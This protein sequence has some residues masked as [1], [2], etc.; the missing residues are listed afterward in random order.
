MDPQAALTREEFYRGKE[1]IREEWFVHDRDLGTWTRLRV[2]SDGMADVWDHG[3]LWGFVNEACARFCIREGRYVHPT[4]AAG[5]PLISEASRQ[6]AEA[7][8]QPFRWGGD[9]STGLTEPDAAPD[10]AGYLLFPI[11]SSPRPPGR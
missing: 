6:Q 1:V 5:G 10:P 9:W 2:F 11:D 4:R 8:E 3:E 7:G